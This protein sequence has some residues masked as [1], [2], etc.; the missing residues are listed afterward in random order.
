[1]SNYNRLKINILKISRREI[2]K[3]NHLNNDMIFIYA[4]YVLYIYIYVS[5]KYL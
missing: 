2:N 1:M 3:E 5:I 4:F